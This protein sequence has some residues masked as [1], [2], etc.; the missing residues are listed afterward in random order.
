MAENQKDVSLDSF[1]SVV[2]AP[3][4]IPGKIE[5][6][7]SLE[8]F[9][10]FQESTLRY[11]AENCRVVSLVDDEILFKEGSFEKTAYVL[12]LGKML[13]Y[14][15]DKQIDYAVPGDY[16]GELSLIDSQPRSASIR[17]LGGAILLEFD[18]AQFYKHLVAE[19]QMV[20]YLFR[21][22]SKRMRLHLDLI[23]SENQKLNIFIHDMRN[24]MIPLQIPEIRLEGLIRSHQDRGGKHSE[25]L[26]VLKKSLEK[27]TCVRNNLSVL[28]EQSLAVSKKIKASYIKESVSIRPLLEETL[29]ELSF[30]KHL[31][32]KK[33]ELNIEG[34]IH[35]ISINS[36]DIKRVLQNLVINAGQASQKDGSI[37]VNAREEGGCLQIKVIDEG[38]GIPDNIQPMLLKEKFTSKP[39]GNGFG[40]LSCRDIIREYHQGEMGFTSEKSKG[41]TFYFSIPYHTKNEGSS[42]QN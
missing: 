2:P 27:V 18:E 38:A 35:D 15:L 24:I 19:P 21:T 14:K 25:D 4:D 42:G 7:K 16:L 17:A 6:L 5:L 34:D 12:I 37:T 10:K 40:L 23:S 30:H 39:D 36:L 26:G 9:G 1:S 32:D 41:T 20:S 3:D 29:E 8:W 11:M 33:L 13:V 28:I 31:K 22:W